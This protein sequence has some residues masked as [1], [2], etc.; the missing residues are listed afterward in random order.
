MQNFK[1]KVIWITGA[2]SGIGREMARRCNA[3][4][5]KVVLSSRRQ[6][7]LEE[8]QKQLAHPKNSLVL[9]LDMEQSLVFSEKVREVVSHFGRIDLLFNNAGISQRSEVHETSVEIDRKIMEVNFFGTV[10]LTKAVLPV[11]KKQKSGHFAVVSSVSGKTGFYERS[12]Y[13]ASKHALHGFFESLM[14]EEDKN[15]IKVTMICPGPVQTNISKN[16]LDPDGKPHGEM[17]AMQKQGMA[18]EECVNKIIH[19]IKHDKLEV[20]ISKGPEAFGMK[21]KALSPAVY[22]KMLKKRNA[23]G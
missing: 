12:A 4:G 17:D 7:E 18:V 20:I 10:A 2:S 19:A 23:R 1:D 3:E 13:A 14:L 15:G 11:M 9:P 16:A 22:F 8:L 6:S 5:A 21:L